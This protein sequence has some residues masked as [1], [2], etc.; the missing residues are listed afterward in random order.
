MYILLRWLLD[1]LQIGRA[2]TKVLEYTTY[3]DLELT[4]WV[5][6]KLSLASAGLVLGHIMKIWSEPRS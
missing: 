2:I 1:P 4:P 5:R 3:E 6:T